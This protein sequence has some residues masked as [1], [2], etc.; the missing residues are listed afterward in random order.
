MSLLQDVLRTQ[1]L[2]SLEKTLSHT[3]LEDG[4]S[5]DELVDV[6]STLRSLAL[7]ADID[8][9]FKVSL[10]GTPARS[11]AGSR[12]SSRPGSR[13]TSPSKRAVR[14]A[15]HM[16]TPGAG[17]SATD[18]LKAFPTEV[19]QRIFG[20]LSNKDLARCALVSRKWSKS[21]TINYGKFRP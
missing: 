2:D 14:S 1:T 21:Q 12:P 7:P 15:L 19:S 9:D 13:A 16:S 20:Q 10:P 4:L 11:R 6:V 3:H 5:E 17:R 8:S 18:P